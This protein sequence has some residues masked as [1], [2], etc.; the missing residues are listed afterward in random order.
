M[1]KPLPLAKRI[2]DGNQFLVRTM[3]ADGGLPAVKPGDASGYWT[4]AE[5]I[6]A[7]MISPWFEHDFIEPI[8]RMAQ[9]L[10]GG[11]IRPR[12]HVGSW[13]LVVGGKK[14]STMATGHAVIGLTLARPLVVSDEFREKLELAVEKGVSWLKKSQDQTGGWG[15]EPSGGRA[16]QEPRVVATFLALRALAQVCESV[17]SSKCVRDGINFL[18]T[19]Y[20][21]HGFRPAEGRH[22]DPCA[23]ARAFVAILETGA[24]NERT[25]FVDHA[26]QYVLSCKPKDRL[27]DLGT[28]I[29]IPD[30]AA[31]QTVFNTNATAELLEL[32][33]LADDANSQQLAL[34]EWFQGN[35]R[36]DGSW[37]L[38]AND[39]VQDDI[40]IWPTNEAVIALSQF[41]RACRFDRDVLDGASSQRVK[42][43]VI[44][45][46]LLICVI[47]TVMLVSARVDLQASW[48]TL[49]DE[50]RSTLW[51]AS[52]IGVAV[53]LIANMMSKGVFWIVHNIR[54]RLKDSV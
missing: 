44:G 33:V 13:P 39:D 2:L 53:G 16:G 8:G 27:W 48:A 36:D 4:T 12:A 10:V 51:W 14:P 47:E 3:N 52:L 43:V 9:F 23:T 31:G 32:F 45:V 37:C 40:I 1:G 7:I 35:Q 11:Q 22:V 30:G 21:G 34:V 28:E 24:I 54:K 26:L 25:E 42:T 6:E 20:D 46:L 29:Y 15:V 18:W 50:F 17:H 41:F 5:T 38:G 19:L 49:P